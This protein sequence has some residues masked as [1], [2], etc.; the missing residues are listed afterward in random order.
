MLEKVLTKD[1]IRL[2]AEVEDWE[3]AV[4]AGG[5]LLLDAGKCRPEYVDA[6]VNTVREM[7]PHM[8]LA[9]GL[10]LAHARPQDGTLEIGLSLLTLKTPVE[11]GSKVND[12]VELVISFCAVDK[13]AHVGILKA[14]AGFLRNEANQRM[15]KEAE[16]AD[17]ILKAFAQQEK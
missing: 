8:V 2:N 12:P 11:F 13:E 3:G 6:M 9:P 17:E 1:V 15:L 16:S 14:L 5:Q 7:G 4:R 10:A